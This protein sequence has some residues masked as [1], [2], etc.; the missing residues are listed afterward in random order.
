MNM[1]VFIVDLENKISEFRDKFYK[2]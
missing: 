2:N 1:Y